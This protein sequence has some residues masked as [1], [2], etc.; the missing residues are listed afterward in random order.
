MLQEVS[1]QVKNYQL[2]PTL[3]RDEY[4]KVTLVGNFTTIDPGFGHFLI[5]LGPH[6]M[7]HLDP[8][9]V[10]FCRKKC[11]PLSHLIPKIIGPAVGLIFTKVCHF[12]VLNFLLDFRSCWIFFSLF[13]DFLTPL[14]DNTLDLIGSKWPFP[15]VISIT[16]ITYHVL[17]MFYGFPFPRLHP[18]PWQ[19]SQRA[20]LQK[21][22]ASLISSARS[23]KYIGYLDGDLSLICQ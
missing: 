6:S 19:P 14:F 15:C 7:A 10:S 4:M 13:L 9:D 16:N 22:I 23:H 8:I 5:S 3:E 12:T 18:L 1:F 17:Q 21:E 2:Q 11:L 20:W